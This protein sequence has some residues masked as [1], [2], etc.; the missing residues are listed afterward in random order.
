M[1]YKFLT[2]IISVI[3]PCYNCEAYLS[4]CLDALLKQSYDLSKIQLILV[5][6][7]STDSTSRII[8][9][10]EICFLERKASFV[11][12]SQENQGVGAAVNNALKHVNGEFLVWLDPDDYFENNALQNL[13]SYL[14]NHDDISYVRGEVNFRA[15]DNPE[16]IVKIGRSHTNVPRNLSDDL[17]IRRDM[18]CLPGCFMARSSIFN[19]YN[20]GMDIYPSRAGQNFQLL[21]P[22]AVSGKCGYVAEVVYNCLIRSDS[23]SHS[24]KSL[25]ADIIKKQEYMNI[26][27]YTLNK[28]TISE[29]N[30]NKL[31]RLANKKFKKKI[32]SRK[33]KLMLLWIIG[34]EKIS[35]KDLFNVIVN[36]VSLHN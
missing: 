31:L 21:L 16:Q 2:D 5:N 24:K 17:I 4:K 33:V 22:L 30:K 14:R 36:K 32:F 20:N 8:D 25:L 7:G 12:I 29:E 6:D 13:Y 26:I 35:T 27:T 10:Y 23:L 34:K 19:E 1:S 11:K 15:V 28:L 9:Q 3:L 18:Y